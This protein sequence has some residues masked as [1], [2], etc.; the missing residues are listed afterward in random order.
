MTHKK[1]TAVLIINTGSPD[2]PD[3]PALKRYLA[4]FLGDNRIIEL[5][6]WK[7]WPILHGIILRVRPKKSAELY[8]HV[9]TE[10]GSPLV[11]ISRRTAQG[12]EKRFEGTPLE[13]V[14]VREAMRY[15]S[16]SIPEVIEEL[17][18]EGVERLLVFPMFAQYC[19]H[20]TVACIDAVYRH[21]MTVRSM[22][23]LRTIEDYHDHPAYI[24][25]M[26]TRIEDYW[27]GHGRAID[28][29]GKLV[30]SFHSVPV[31]GVEA[32]DVY[33]ERCRRTASLLVDTLG[34]DP[35]GGDVL[36]TFQS[37][38]GRDPW[39]EPFTLDTAK[40]LGSE[41]CPSLD[42]FCP[43]FAADC[44]ETLEEMA[45]SLKRDYVAS[46]KASTAEGEPRFD[47]IPALNDSP[48]ALD[49]YY[50]IMK[51]ELAGWF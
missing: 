31:K 50:E 39:V 3:A 33:V 27:A 26:K 16:P 11:V 23:Q 17:R 21:A 6:R 46:Y 13:G 51:E 37:R 24:R 44:L 47:Y 29:G 41:G 43:G 32:G 8:R 48:E 38:Y 36:V 18:A 14:L 9:W 7:W 45:I 28:R 40:R 5:P 4:E 1:K 30:L 22:P 20:T 42:V 10:E 25:A 49:A 19:M 12:L 15:G 35:D 34:L 2:A